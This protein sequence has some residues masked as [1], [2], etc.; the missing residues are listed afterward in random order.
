VAV[1]PKEWA[2]TFVD[3]VGI[4]SEDDAKAEPLI[5]AVARRRALAELKALASMMCGRCQEGQT[6]GPN[7]RH[8]SEDA[9][10]P[11]EGPCYAEDLR[12]RIAEIEAEEA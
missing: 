3:L 1:D 5:Y 2:L 12:D 11:Y 4:A 10:S 7:G 9:L 8:I 6:Y